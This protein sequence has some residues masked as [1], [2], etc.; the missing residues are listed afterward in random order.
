MLAAVAVVAALLSVPVSAQALSGVATLDGITVAG[1]DL[2]PGFSSDVRFYRVDV[3]HGEDR[4]TVG[5]DKGHPAQAVAFED[6]SGAGLADVDAGEAGHQV[7]LAYG[8]NTV[9]LVVTPADAAADAAVYTLSIVRA[10]PAAVDGVSADRAPATVAPAGLDNRPVAANEKRLVFDTQFDT[11]SVMVTE[12]SRD[13]YGV[14]LSALPSADVT[15][16]VSASAGG[17][18]V[19]GRAADSGSVLALTFGTTDW[20]TFQSVNVHA[21]DDADFAIDFETLHHTASGGGYDGATGDVT[22]TVADNDTG[23]LVLDK[24]LLTIPEGSHREVAVKLSAE[25]S[26]NVTLSVSVP[27]GA[28]SDLVVTRHDQSV[29]VTGSHPVL[30]HTFTTRNWDRFYGIDMHGTHDADDVDDV[31]TLRYTV[32]GADHDFYVDVPVRVVDDE[33]GVLVFDSRWVSVTEGSHSEYGVKL[34]AEP[35]GEVTVEVSVP[36]GDDSDLVLSTPSAGSV[37]VS[38]SGSVLALTFGT[39][40]WDTYQ[41]VRVHADEDEDAGDDFETLRHAVSGD[42]HDFYADVAVT[43]ED[44]GTLVFSDTAVSVPE[45]SHVEYGVKLGAEP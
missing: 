21:D 39:A 45:G 32:S 23:A 28:G 18:L 22:V 10:E 4:A 13:K 19:L 2:S 5:F 8:V 7:D 16:V 34:G 26:G 14:K 27:N 43:V 38:D 20:D 37:S 44:T 3:V 15:V 35:S 40:D 24:S 25:P 29:H 42:G 31:H 36:G 17:D 33:S 6:G 41:S 12:G 11:R 9:R 1:G 30:E